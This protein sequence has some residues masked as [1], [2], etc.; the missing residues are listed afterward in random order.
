MASLKSSHTGHPHGCLGKGAKTVSPLCTHHEQHHA[1]TACFLSN[2]IQDPSTPALGKTSWGFLCSPATLILPFWS[3]LATSKCPPTRS[4]L[5]DDGTQHA[6]A[7]GAMNQNQAYTENH[8]REG[9]KGENSLG[10][11]MPPF[12]STLSSEIRMCFSYLA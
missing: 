11:T 3:L 9:K 6:I 4:T 2:S 5:I 12:Q 10:K 8:E 1:E 7:C